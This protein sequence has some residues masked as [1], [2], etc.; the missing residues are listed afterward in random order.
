MP[1]TA[2]LTYA[3]VWAQMENTAAISYDRHNPA[4]QSIVAYRG[5]PCRT[6]LKN[7]TKLTARLLRRFESI[8]AQITKR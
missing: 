7:D 8:P 5:M 1:L 6:S 2:S 3:S 4:W